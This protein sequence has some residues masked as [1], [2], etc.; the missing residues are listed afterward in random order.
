VPYDLT[1]SN[2]T[3]VGIP[4]PGGLLAALAHEDGRSYRPEP[5]GLA[6]AREAVARD[7][8]RHGTEVDRER[9]G[10]VAS[11]SEA[12]SFLFKLLCDPGDAVLAPV[13]SY[14]LLEHLAA[15]EGV[16]RLSYRLGADDGWQPEPLPL[17]DTPV[18]AVVAVN[19]NNPTGSFVHADGA[20]RLAA[21]CTELRAALIVDEVFLDYPL[22]PTATAPTLASRGEVLTF[23]LGGLSKSLGLPQLKLAWI[24]LSGPEPQVVR[25]RERLE[26]IADNYLSVG[27]PV[28]LA[29][30]RLLEEAV[31][32]R[33]AILERCRL[34]LASLHA[35]GSA[36]PGLRVREPEAGWSVV[37][38]YPGVIG[39]EAL[40]LELLDRHG[41]A[42]YPGYFFDFARPG[43][44]VLS[45]L[46]EPHVFDEGV[47]RLLDLLARHL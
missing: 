45:L 2:P 40:V 39:E 33:Q 16:R 12:Y 1:V 20:R 18:R 28:Q 24:V 3:S 32:I 21:A 46:P 11:T 31:V 27:T 34:N 13:P 9:I 4:Y 23:T 7:C 42:V 14:P 19:P 43:T 47:R 22:A 26:F 17:A 35:A 10:L 6:S 37:L 44:L 30:P 15:L 25:A 5:F 36:L 8:R 38:E 29:L 41:V